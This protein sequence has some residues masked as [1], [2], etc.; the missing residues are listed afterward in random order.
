MNQQYYPPR[1]LTWQW[2]IHHLK[3]YFLLKMEIFQCHSLVSRGV[4]GGGNSKYFVCWPRTLE[5][6]FHPFLT[7]AYLFSKWVGEKQAS[8]RCLLGIFN[9]SL[10]GRFRGCWWMLHVPGWWWCL[11]CLCFFSWKRRNLK[12]EARGTHVI[13]RHHIAWF[14]KYSRYQRDQHSLYS[15]VLLYLFESSEDWRHTPLQVECPSAL[16]RRCRNRLNDGKLTRGQICLEPAIL[17][18]ICQA[19]DKGNKTIAK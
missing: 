10:G 8:N 14:L 5:E 15:L 11:C 2:K 7:N 17:K 4:L 16:F 3:M 13:Q 12:L 9:P 6:D 1:N 19:V 18:F